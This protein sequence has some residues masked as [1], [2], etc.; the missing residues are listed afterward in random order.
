MIKQ[1]LPVLLTGAFWICGVQAAVDPAA[2]IQ[3]LGTSRLLEERHESRQ[4]RLLLS[5]PRKTVDRVTTQDERL[6]A[7]DVWRRVWE[8]PGRLE[9]AP[10]LEQVRSALAA[11]GGVTELFSCRDLACG[12][13]HYWANEIFANGRLVG[14]DTGQR[15]AALELDAPSGP[16][17]VVLYASHRGAR[18]TVVAMDVIRTTE[19]LD[20]AA[21]DSADL[22]RRLS[23]QDGWL[24]GMVVRDGQLDASA[25]A[26]LV[27]A[28]KGLPEGSKQ[29]LYLLVHCYDSLDMT[30]NRQCSEQL[31]DQLRLQ[32][33]DGTTQLHVEGQGA[34][35]LPA[36][37]GVQPALRF[38]FWPE[39]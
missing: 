3:D 24:P 2:G 11:D 1:W 25:S 18:Q 7:A 5:A 29:R 37:R 10:L 35:V 15:Y 34:L 27:A 30:V 20:A 22:L 33:F 28:L 6:L 14:R 21:A 16:Q 23:E 12:S 8:V 19:R 31:A 9:L 32:T 39:R 4:Y 13:S 26:G 36:D 38:V 17:L